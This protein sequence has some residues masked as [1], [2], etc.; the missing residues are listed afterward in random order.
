MMRC[1]FCSIDSRLF[2]AADAAARVRCQ[3]APAPRWQADGGL[4]A[5]KRCRRAALPG[6]RH[7]TASVVA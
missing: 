7:F 3:M 4:M 6:A 1:D 2:R 5:M